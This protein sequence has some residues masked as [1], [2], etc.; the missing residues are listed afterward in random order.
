SESRRLRSAP[1]AARI[2]QGDNDAGPGCGPGSETE[3]LSLLRRRAVAHVRGSRDVAAREFVRGARRPQPHGAV[4]SAPRPRL[5]ALPAGTAAG[6]RVVGAHLRPL[7]LLFLVL[8]ELAAA[9]ARLLRHD[10]AAP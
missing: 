8:P 1:P 10:R 7:C 5:R 9:R 4:L 6:G 2:A 3:P